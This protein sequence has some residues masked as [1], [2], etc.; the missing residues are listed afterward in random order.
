MGRGVQVDSVHWCER[1]AVLR[2]TR[3][4][5]RTEGWLLILTRTAP[6][7]YWWEWPDC[8]REKEKEKQ[9]QGKGG[10]AGGGEGGTDF[11]LGTEVTQ[12]GGQIHTQ[13][14]GGVL[15]DILLQYCRGQCRILRN[16]GFIEWLTNDSVMKLC[17]YLNL[18]GY[19]F[20]GT[21]KYISKNAQAALLYI[22]RVRLHNNNVWRTMYEVF[23]LCFF[24]LR[25]DNNIVKTIP[26]HTDPWKWL[27][28]LY[29]ACQARS[30]RCDIIKNIYANP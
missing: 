28:T 30:W 14:C 21:K 29:Y 15:A 25:I 2:K 27:E 24:F 16:S 4:R 19:F 5:R 10:G 7:T 12:C 8:K 20:C 13:G 9:N 11:V 17:H 1:H 6:D 26:I 22:L 23:P 18:N 3:R